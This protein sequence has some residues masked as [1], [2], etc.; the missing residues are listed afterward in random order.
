MSLSLSDLGNL[1]AKVRERDRVMVD[2]RKA[3]KHLESLRAEKRDLTDKVLAREFG[4]SVSNL[5]RYLERR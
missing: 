2:L 4:I 1:Y 3:R 5:R